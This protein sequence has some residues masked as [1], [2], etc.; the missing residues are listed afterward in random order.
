MTLGGSQGPNP[1][2]GELH[3]KAI[4][5]EDIK[6]VLRDVLIERFGAKPR[7]NSESKV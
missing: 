7:N 2:V 1:S 3:Q 6:A 5:A 4:P